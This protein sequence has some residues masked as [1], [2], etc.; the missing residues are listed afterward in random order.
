M[1]HIQRLQEEI[2]SKDDRLEENRV[3]IQRL[4]EEIERKD[5]EL[6]RERAEHRRANEEKEWLHQ[7]QLGEKEEIIRRLQERAPEKSPEASVFLNL[8]NT[9]RDWC[10]SGFPFSKGWGG[11]GRLCKY[12]RKACPPPPPPPLLLISPSIPHFKLDWKVVT[13]PP[14]LG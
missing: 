14:S 8:S 9:I 12:M 10:P 4:Q 3:H 13:K 7:E 11:V 6:E 5:G 2:E 1:G